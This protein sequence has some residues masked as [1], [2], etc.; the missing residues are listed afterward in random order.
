[1]ISHRPGGS[2]GGDGE[3]MGLEGKASSLR[4]TYVEG[5]GTPEGVNYYSNTW[6]I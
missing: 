4:K 3:W 6:P 2:S 5:T 1:M